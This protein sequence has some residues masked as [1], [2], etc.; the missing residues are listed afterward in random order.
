VASVTG[1]ST[2]G[3][4]Q[5]PARLVQP[6]RLAAQAA[7]RRHFA[8]QEALVH[9]GRIEPA[10]WG[11]VKRGASR[12]RSCGFHAGRSSVVRAS[13]DGSA[14]RPTRRTRSRSEDSKLSSRAK[15]RFPGPGPCGNS[16][17]RRP[18]SSGQNRER[19]PRR[20][21]CHAVR[22]WQPAPALA[23]LRRKNGAGSP[24]STRRIRVGSRMSGPCA[25]THLSNH[26]LARRNFLPKTATVCFTNVDETQPGG[27]GA[28]SRA[29]W[30]A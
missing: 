18:K 12:T 19:L 1:W 16:G 22:T 9:E 4:W 27:A 21:L 29:R 5:D 10:P 25:A 15:S 13:G 6:Q 28:E 20:R 8:D 17:R 24:D 30:L 3:R 2:A 14:S 11:K 26:N 7:S 23:T